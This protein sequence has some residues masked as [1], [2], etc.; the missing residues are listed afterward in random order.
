M[1]SGFG[2]TRRTG[3]ALNSPHPHLKL[4]GAFEA[5]FQ[6]RMASYFT[7]ISGATKLLKF[8]RISRYSALLLSPIH[9]CIAASSGAQDSKNIH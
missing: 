2:D 5:L 4:T 9:C 3:A 7:K 8:L 1:P 6:T